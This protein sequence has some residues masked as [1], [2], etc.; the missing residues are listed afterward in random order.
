MN[1]GV[2]KSSELFFPRKWPVKIKRVAREI[3]RITGQISKIKDLTLLI[4]F[5]E[6]TGKEGKLEH[7]R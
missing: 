1:K 3:F 4:S 5:G 2:E 6:E 7:L